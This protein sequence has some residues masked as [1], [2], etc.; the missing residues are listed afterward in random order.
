MPVGWFACLLTRLL[1]KLWLTVRVI[2]ERVVRLGTRNKRLD[3]ASD[4]HSH[5]DPEIVSLLRLFAMCK[6]ALRSLGVSTADDFSY[7]P[8]DRSQTFSLGALP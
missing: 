5:L 1:G 7:E 2:F 4:L 8:Q 3:S 6:A